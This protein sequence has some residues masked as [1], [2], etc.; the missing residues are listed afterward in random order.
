MPIYEKSTR[1]LMHEFA[2]QR[3]KPGQVFSR[4]D[5]VLWFAD[6]YPDIKSNTVSARGV[7]NFFLAKVRFRAMTRCAGLW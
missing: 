3:L 2:S 4:K 5:A 7:Q 6:R 1:D